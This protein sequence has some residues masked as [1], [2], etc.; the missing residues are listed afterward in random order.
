MKI[1]ADNNTK[2]P[3]DE[4]I[5]KEIWVLCDYVETS[6]AYRSYVRFLKKVVQQSYTLFY[7]N[8]IFT[9]TFDREDNDT[10]LSMSFDTTVTLAK[11]IRPIEPFTT[12]TTQQLFPN[13]AFK[14]ARSRFDEFI[15][16]PVWIKISNFEMGT[17]YVKILDRNK[18][19]VTCESID[20]EYVDDFEYD[21]QFRSPSTYV[22]DFCFQI[23]GFEICNPLEILTDDEMQEILE[24]NDRVWL[25][26]WEAEYGEE[27]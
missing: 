13:Y 14:S 18:N 22:D 19:V 2:T 24:Y 3:F 23:D 17:L 25:E 10:L 26:G 5:G 20:S 27:E 12:F 21:D 4:Y 9:S 16:Q 6:S 1:Y 8:V 11:N 15:G 7:V